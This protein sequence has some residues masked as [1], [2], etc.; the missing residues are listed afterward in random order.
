VQNKK[1]EKRNR[2]KKGERDELVNRGEREMEK[3]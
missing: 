1:N 3:G 2:K